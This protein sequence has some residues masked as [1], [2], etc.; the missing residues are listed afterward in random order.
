MTTYTY[1]AKDH[2]G[3]EIVGLK[4][5]GSIDEVIGE[6][7]GQGL[8]ILHIAEGQS[9][10]A[11]GWRE[12]LKAS[13]LGTARTRDL[14]L[15]SRQFATV[16]E[17]GIP[18]NRGLRGLASD[19]SSRVIGRAVE[20]IA[21]RI[22]RG[23]SLSEAMAA[24]PEAFNQMYL[25]LIR[26]GEQAGTLDQMVEQLATYLEKVDTIKTKVRA[27]MSYPIFTL[28]F[29]VLAV[30]FLLL[31]VVPTFTDIYADMN[32]QLPAL[33]RG[34][35]AVSKAVTSHALLVF[36]A[37]GALLALLI[38]WGQTRSGRYVR[39]LLVLRMPVFGSI[40]RKAV[41]SRLARTFG[42]LL[43]SG[44]PILESL[45]LVGAASGNVV[46]AAAVD[47]AKQQIGT[48]RSITQSFRSTGR[49]PEMILQLMS[50]GEESGEMD[51]M[52]IKASDFYDRQVEASVNGIASLIEPLMIVIVGA[53]IGIIVISVFLPVF[54]LGDA[55]MKGG[56]NL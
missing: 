43:K 46:V 7:H 30:L 16:L 10:A 22:E 23:Q 32:Q 1:I 48:G 18:L 42:V 51:A 39:D 15:F 26:A 55:I 33:T 45:T 36:A 25:S 4:S 11:G 52:L 37:V 28:S 50:T 19:S 31:K 38:F 5:G 8:S 40:V 44:L 12:R 56:F 14:A 29:A 41:M 20:D 34:V 49:F 53:L 9:S 13:L 21:D 6:L 24:H 27:A 47:R 54:Y 35:I 2:Q 3:E 17:A